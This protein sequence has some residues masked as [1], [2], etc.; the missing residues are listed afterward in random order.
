MKKVFGF[1]F[2]LVLVL[3]LA[4]CFGGASDADKVKE[5]KEDLKISFTVSGN[6]LNNVT[7]NLILVTTFKGVDVTWTTDNE[8]VVK[9]NGEVTQGEEDVSVNLVASLKLNEETDSKSF[10]VKVKKAGETEV[11]DGTID[12]SFHNLVEDKKVYVTSIGQAGDLATVST[13]L[14]RFVYTTE[15]AAEFE[16]KVTVEAMLTANQVEEG[17][18]VILVPG[19]SDKGLGAAGTNLNNEKARAEAFNQR[20]KAGEITVIVVH[21]GGEP[22]R[23]ESTDPLIHASVSDAAIVLVV[24]TANFD[25]FFDNL[26]ND[27]V[28]LYASVQDLADPFKLIFGKE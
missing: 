14:S 7:G 15:E 12:E 19:A 27:F 3:S 4:A 21:N 16:E 26:E 28:Y 2:T 20:A 22:R 10:T 13:L 18:I 17:S 23:G 1:I 25:G 9:N 11:N 24:E 6:N 8:D 5:A